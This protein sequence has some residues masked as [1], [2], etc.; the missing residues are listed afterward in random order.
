M[1]PRKLGEIWFV[2]L[3]EQLNEQLNDQPL[4]WNRR[5]KSR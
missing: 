5:R 1:P 4:A 2:L 3:N